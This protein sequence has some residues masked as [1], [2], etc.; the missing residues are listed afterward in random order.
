MKPLSFFSVIIGTEL[1]NGR[2]NDSHFGHVNSELIRRGWEHKGSFIVSDEPDLL[3]KTFS[4]L[5]EREDSVFFSFGGIGSTPDDYTREIAAQV[6]REGQMEIHPEVKTILE[7]RFGEKAYPNRIQMA[8]LPIRSELVP[9]PVNNVP[10]FSLDQRCFFL[11]GFPEMAHPMVTWAL[12]RYFPKNVKKHRKTVSVLTSEESLIAFMK[13]LPKS[14]ELSSL[15]A[16]GKQGPMVT[17]SLGS[18]HEN[19][20]DEWFE[21]L[22]GIIHENNW[23]YNLGESF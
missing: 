6:F 10:G 3:I 16:M 1:L 8:N 12:E 4:M 11:P 20:V 14:I 22:M 21:K 23:T 17:M 9:N 13:V 18:Y 19:E 2:R 7:E 5:K 15:P